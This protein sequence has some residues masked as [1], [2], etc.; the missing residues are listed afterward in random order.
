MTP[1]EDST[2]TSQTKSASLELE[3]KHE[4]SRRHCEAGGSLFIQPLACSA[5]AILLLSKP[6]DPERCVTRALSFP[7]TSP[8]LYNE[9]AK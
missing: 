1:L 6:K 2:A 8:L 5:I 4:P 3:V 9:Y 7:G